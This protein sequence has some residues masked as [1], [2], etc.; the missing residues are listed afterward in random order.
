MESAN[1]FEHYRAFS[2]TRKRG[3]DTVTVYEQGI[4]GPVTCLDCNVNVCLK[5]QTKKELASHLLHCT[6]AKNRKVRNGKM[7][8]HVSKL[9]INH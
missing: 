9:A 1:P 6:A 3:E 5:N 8:A 2:K 7:H 4:N